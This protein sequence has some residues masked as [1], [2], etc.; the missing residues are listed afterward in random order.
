MVAADVARRSEPAGPD[1]RSDYVINFRPSP[2]SFVATS[3]T[4]YHFYTRTSRMFK[5]T[6]QKNKKIK[7]FPRANRENNMKDI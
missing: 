2:R 5:F 1:S 3:T 6:G 4:N 7:N